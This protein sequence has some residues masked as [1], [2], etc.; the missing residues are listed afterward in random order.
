MRLGLWL[1][2]GLVLCSFIG[3]LAAYRR[4]TPLSDTPYSRRHI[5]LVGASI[6]KAWDLKNWPSRAGVAA[7]TAECVTA[8]KFDKSEVIEELLMRPRLPVHFT[9]T[10][11]KS[12]FLPAP[13]TPSVFILKEC[14]SYFPGD[15]AVYTSQ[16]RCW[17]QQIQLRGAKVIV[18]TV[19]PVTRS[20][21][22]QVPGKNETLIVFN[23]WVR[24]YTK[25]TGVTLLDLEASVRVGDTARYLRDD[26]TTGD[27]THLNQAGYVILDMELEKVLYRLH[28]A[29]LTR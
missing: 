22:A 26:L 7:V 23:E 1:K 21:A 18:A 8:W 28:V 20:R 15:L 10:Y 13:P 4:W 2:T 12:L 5:V 19:V 24:D 16:V 17:V 25:R 27:G 9:R 3:G 29:H 6:G 11:L 14:S